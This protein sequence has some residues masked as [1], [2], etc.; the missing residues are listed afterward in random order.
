[1]RFMIQ[2]RPYQTEA[3]K[4]ILKRWKDGV[5]RQLV[6][7][8]TG[9]GKTLLFGMVAG[10]LKTRTLVLAHREELLLQA[11]QKIRLVYPE[12]DVGILKAEER[13]GLRTDICVASVQTA[14][15]NT[16]ALRERG[17]RLLICDEAHHAAAA[18]TEIFEALGF[19]EGDREKL[20]LGVTAT[21]YRGD[22]V[23]LGSVFE[24]IVFERSILAMMKAGYLCDVRGLEIKTGADISGVRTRTGDFA[25]DELSVVIDTPERNALVA[26]TYLE[27]GEG[28][29]GVVFGVGVE[30]ALNLAEAFRTRG[31]PCAAVYGAMSPEERH[32]ALR[33]Y[34]DGKLRVLTNVGV[35]TEGWDVPDTSVVMMARPTKSKGLYIQC[36]GRGL[37]LAPGK[38]DCLLVDFADVAKKHK[39]CS[40]GTLAGDPLL[41]R[42]RKQTLLEAVE[43]AEKLDILRRKNG[44]EKIAHDAESFDLFERSRFVWQPLERHY[45]LRLEDGSSL[46][47]K[48]VPGG[49]SPI[50]FPRSGEIVALSEDV[51]PLGYAMGVCED[52]ARQLSV[53]KTAMKSASWRKEGATEKQRKA[54][55]RMGVP[56][57]PDISKGEA[58]RLLDRKFGVLATGSQIGFLRKRSLHP[59]PELLTKHEAT[60]IIGRY[61]KAQ[62]IPI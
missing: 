11:R 40:F 15:R 43:E 38:E 47:C 4:K 27:H 13:S 18:Y 3:L 42:R 49:Y 56:F 61:M 24:E 10:A 34:E 26:D 20:L 8:P 1:M 12:A 32:D 44:L 29:R 53:A 48:Y 36:V 21:A 58:S 50:L 55:K 5:T 39:L 7:L 35:L 23:G 33:R 59:N 22:N 51:L 30:H 28:R 45:K 2:P 9:T 37:R 14:M 54:L 57:D 16:D 52:Y 41:K 25:L 46:W 19:M 31:I 6:S 62:K 60:K 17:F